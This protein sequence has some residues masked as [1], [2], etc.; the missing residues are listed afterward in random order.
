[1]QNHNGVGYC[2]FA[3]SCA[4]FQ[5]SCGQNVSSAKHETHGQKGYTFWNYI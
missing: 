5:Y 2:L 3:N 1:M 4:C